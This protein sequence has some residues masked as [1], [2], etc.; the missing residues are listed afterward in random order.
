MATVAVVGAGL[1]AEGV[2]W[3]LLED[4]VAGNV[5]GDE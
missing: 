3:G 5:D 2:A 1:E 4:V